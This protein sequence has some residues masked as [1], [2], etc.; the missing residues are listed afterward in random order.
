MMYEAISHD[1][2]NQTR[3]SCYNAKR[4]K[5]TS[6]RIF[7]ILYIFFIFE[8]YFY[9]NISTFFLRG[10]SPQGCKIKKLLKFKQK[11]KTL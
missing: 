11:I 3:I 8:F 5:F 9:L 7:I 2:K 6:Q 10:T 4:S 1:S